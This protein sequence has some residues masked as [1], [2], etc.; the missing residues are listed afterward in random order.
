MRM[1][2]ISE[3]MKLNNQ[4]IGVVE[5]ILILVILIALVILFRDQITILVTNV[6]A[7]ISENGDNIINTSIAPKASWR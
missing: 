5:I 3:R 1:K 6:F 4:G 2:R 7:K